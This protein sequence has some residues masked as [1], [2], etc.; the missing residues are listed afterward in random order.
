M[1]TKDLSTEEPRVALKKTLLICAAILLAAAFL[2]V[3]IF[4]TEPEA[5]REA[6]TRKTAMLVDV[7]TVE[8]GDF[9]PTINAMG[10]VI[11]A[12]SVM[13]QP[14]VSGHVTNITDNFFPGGRVKEGDVLLRLD[15]SD[16]QN[17]LQ[18]RQSELAQATTALEIEMGEQAI[19]ER[20][21]RRI[22]GGRNLTEMQRALV[23]R[24][25]QL[26]AARAR[27]EAA[28]ANLR[29]AQ[30]DL[31]RTEIKAP[32]DAQ[33]L[34]RLANVGSQVSPADNLA[35]LVGVQTYWVEATM[36]MAHLRWIKVGGEEANVLIR[37]RT[38][39]PEGEFRRGRLH[40][41]IGELEGRTRM[42]RVLIEVN[43]PLAVEPDNNGKM[44][45]IIGAFVECRIQAE[46]LQNIVRIERALIR[47]NN[48][49]W[50]MENNV[51]AIREL[52][53]ALRDEQ[54]AY[55]ESGLKAGDKVVTTGLSAVTEG[56]ELRLAEEASADG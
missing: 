23:L 3:I 29:Q 9:R 19:A 4:S 28:R 33:V 46:A 52:E 27:V 42:A 17:Q 34:S 54:Y 38:A 11:P 20:D 18:Q 56:A 16:Y 40:S 25:P 5:E 13:L 8:A 43:D 24:E 37:N 51:L 47:K 35:D 10:T 49:A 12:Q 32:F 14:R 26:N 50:V 2:T 22:E 21:F 7:T 30:L 39:W 44:P 6:A 36:P 15:P 1:P 41:V 53:I 45:L 55:V 31:E 48:T